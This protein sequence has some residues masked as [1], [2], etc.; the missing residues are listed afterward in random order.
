VNLNELFAANSGLVT[1]GQLLSVISRKALAS[2]LQAGAI[3][4]VFHGVYA[5]EPPDIIGRLAALEL[6]TGRPIVACMGTAAEFHG[7]DIEQDGRLHVLDP[8]VRIRPNAGLMVHQRTGAPLRRV[9]GRLVTTAAWTAVEVARTKQRRRAL[10][11]LDA[12]L[13]SGSCT[14]AD[15]SNAVVEQKGRRGIVAVREL[16][17]RADPR[18]ESPM[19]SEARLVFSDGGLP[20]PELQFEII[21]RLGDLWRVDFAWPEF[22]VVAEYD[23]MEWHANPERWKRDRIKAARLGELG[24]TTLPFVVDDVRRYPAELVAR[25]SQLLTVG[26]LAG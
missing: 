23:S 5:L 10:A 2:H 9:Q 1:T 18:A 26:R 16:L 12:A 4:R 15:L 25:V 11:T 14:P 8:G 22:R 21:D 3:T 6:V 17:P 7:F 20:D 13:R 24:W 19:E